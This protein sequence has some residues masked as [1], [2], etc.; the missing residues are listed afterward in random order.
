MLD[1]HQ[2]LTIFSGGRPGAGT[3]DPPRRTFCAPTPTRRPARRSGGSPDAHGA[4]RWL[5]PPGEGPGDT[6]HRHREHLQQ[7]ARVELSG[8]WKRRRSRDRGF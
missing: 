2:T 1:P 4:A 3:G 8:G 5:R 7:L 6:G